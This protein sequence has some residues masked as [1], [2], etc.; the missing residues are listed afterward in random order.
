MTPHGGTGPGTVAFPDL[1]L[2]R[3]MFV[4]GK[5]IPWGGGSRVA[6]RADAT[7]TCPVQMSF[8]FRN[9]GGGPAQNVTA[10]IRDSLR[11][12][13]PVARETLASM[14]AGQ[15]S[16]VGGVLKVAAAPAARRVVLVARVHEAGKIHEK[17]VANDHGSITLSVTCR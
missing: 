3:G 8:R 4:R 13:I 10:A 11:P 9:A 14:T 1:A 17:N 15:S 16:S 2:G 12:M 6:L 5:L 7:H